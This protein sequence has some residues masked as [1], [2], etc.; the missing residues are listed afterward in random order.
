LPIPGIVGIAQVFHDDGTFGE[1][2][3][4]G[5]FDLILPGGVIDTKAGR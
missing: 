2:K 1:V 3:G 5:F 4:P